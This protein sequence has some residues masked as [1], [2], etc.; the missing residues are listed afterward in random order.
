MNSDVIKCHQKIM[1]TIP[2]RRL[3]V[4]PCGD[5]CIFLVCEMQGV[6]FVYIFSFSEKKM[7][8]KKKVSRSLFKGAGLVQ[9]KPFWPILAIFHQIDHGA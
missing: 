1:W 7:I 6:I 4:E 2:L 3:A 9:R 8:K 5:L